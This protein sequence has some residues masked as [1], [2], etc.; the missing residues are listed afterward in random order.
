MRERYLIRYIFFFDKD[1]IDNNHRIIETLRNGKREEKEKEV[2]KRTMLL[3]EK[4]EALDKNNIEIIDGLKRIYDE[5]QEEINK[6]KVEVLDK[7]I[8][9]K[10]NNLSKY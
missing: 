3:K 5:L 9:Q 2:E 10:G 8:I 1:I 4:A 6:S 7:E